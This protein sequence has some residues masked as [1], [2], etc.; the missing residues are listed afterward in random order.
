MGPTSTEDSGIV[1]HGDI[2]ID[3]ADRSQALAVLKHVPASIARD[4]T[5]VKHNT[6]VYFTEI[7]VDPE[8]GIAGIDHETAENR[9]YYKLDL[10]NVHVYSQVRDEQHLN[11]LMAR[12]APW[13]KLSDPE[14]FAR[15]IHI[16]NHYSVA[17]QM[18]E[19]ID[20]IQRMS[21]FLSLIRPGKRHL[22]GLKWAEVAKTV[23]DKTEEGYSFKKAHAVGYAHLVAVHMNLLDL[24]DQGN[25][26]AL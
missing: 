9:G 15:V 5:L 2:D 23:W 14:F 19:P 4:D 6:G 26:S 20:S 8:L 25:N 24:A 21:M 22:V 18:P 17:Q 10:L 12:P 3:F 16:G 7:P 11:E 1:K 13:D